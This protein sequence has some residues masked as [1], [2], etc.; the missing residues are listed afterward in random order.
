MNYISAS[1]VPFRRF[2]RWSVLPVSLFVFALPAGL[3]AQTVAFTGA[4]ATVGSGFSVPAG[5]ATDGAGDVFVADSGNGTVHEILAVGGSIPAS[6]TIRTLGS[7]F[8]V[9]ASVAVDGAGNVFVA[10][11]GN[12]AVYEMLAV[13]GSV[14]ASPTIRTLGSGTFIEPVGLAVDG[15]GNLY[16][17]DSKS[18][19]LYEVMAVGGS[20]PT[21]YSIRTLNSVFS[22]PWG[23]AVDGSGD[24]FVAD[25]GFK[26]LYELVAVGGSIPASPTNRALAVD[27]S[28][29]LGVAVDGSG[30]IYVTDAGNGAVYELLAVDGSIPASAGIQMASDLLMLDGKY[31][32]AEPWGVAVDGS[33]NVYV[34]DDFHGA[35]KEHLGSG[36]NFGTKNEGSTSAFLP[37]QFTVLA[38]GTAI[39][40]A[41][42]TEGAAGLDFA[43]AGTGSCAAN[44]TSHAYSAGD[45]CT[46]DVTFTPR[47]AGL[48]RGAVLVLNA[49]NGDV[50]AT[51]PIY[52]IGI[53]PQ[54]GF[55]SGAQIELGSGLDFTFGV[56]V[57]GAGDVFI[58]DVN[59]SRVVEVPVDGGPE[60]TVATGLDEPGCIAVDGAGNV[61][62]ADQNNS[63]VLKL[64]VGGGQPTTVGTGL[65]APFG[66]AVDGPG[67]VFISDN[68]NK[69]VVEV[70]ANGSAQITAVSGLG[71]PEGIAVDGAGDIFIADGGSVLEAP[72]GGGSLIPV[73]GAFSHPVGVAVDAAG[74]VFVA[75]ED[76]SSLIE[77]PAGGGAQILMGNSSF[78]HPAGVAVGAAGDLFVADN[79][80]DR[81]VELPYSRIPSLNFNSGG[82]TQTVAAEN[83]GN[84]P[85]ALPGIEQQTNPAISD[86]SFTLNTTGAADCAAVTASASI[87]GTLGPG[88]ACGLPITFS[89]ANGGTQGGTLV[90]TDNSLTGSPTVFTSQT[91]PLSGTA[92]GNLPSITWPSPAAISYGSALSATQLNATANVAGSFTYAP[93]SGAVLGVGTHTLSVIF[94]PT[95][96]TSYVTASSTVTL[97]VNR[98]VPAI[99]W[100]TPAAITYGTVLSATQLDATSPVAGNFA[101][102]PPAGT[103]LIPGSQTLS[104]TF[105]PTDSADFATVTDS[106]QLTV[107]KDSQT[108]SFTQPASPVAAGVSPVTLSATGGAS[109]N[110]VTFSVVSGPGTL[111]GTNDDVLIVTG[112]GTI[113]LAANQAGN[114][115][116][117]AAAQVTRSVVVTGPP[118][119]MTSP[120][121]GSTLDGPSVTFVW[122]AAANATGYGLW[123]GSTGPGSDNLYYSGEKASTV[124]SLTVSG[125]PVNG[126]TVYVRLIT[127][128]TSS[129]A[130]INYTYTA[131][132]A[133]ALTTPTPGSS[134]AGPSVTFSWSSAANATGYALWAGTT[135]TG[136]GA[137]NLY[138]SGEKASTVASLTVSGLPVNGETIY[139][140]L[141]TYYGA[142]SS[143]ATYTYTS[144]IGGILTTPAPGSKLTGPSVTFGWSVGAGATGYALWIGSTGMGSDNLY[145]SGEKASTVTSLAVSGLPTNGE[146]I[147]VRLITYYGGSSTFFNYT[148]TAATAAVLTTPAPGSTLEGSSVTFS[149]TAAAN[150][151]G[152]ALWAGNSPTESDNLYYSGE[153]AP[154]VT[155][156]TAN[157]L[158]MNGET[159]YVRLITYYGG[160]SAFINYTYTAQ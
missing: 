123:I 75:D 83:I 95:N 66:V 110:P 22:E 39:R 107:S 159:I 42:L 86:S 16:V 98:A 64:P 84:L 13:S 124:N 94:T 1:P 131:A 23:V 99:T 112:P 47:Y 46:V 25:A 6:P 17:A 69:V 109:G 147:Y 24:V 88:Q 62:I 71:G 57:D 12:K 28:A 60:T 111:S 105:T 87:P 35:V 4:G 32:F 27:F 97:T 127:Y 9:P 67:D 151:T 38:S 153:K 2:I 20:I 118:A 116:Y 81:V 146:A 115:I 155:S 121:P 36:T 139:V 150:A 63:R 59:N 21:L 34:S 44:G 5:V 113:V 133:A 140:R 144:A 85:L 126:E 103:G 156:L 3:V 79:F 138:Y 18:H 89:P 30:N 37:L 145:Y 141:I 10:D 52:G 158:P 29:P 117:A 135:G 41:V 56:A 54:I 65:A 76:N 49:E 26:A 70:P 130:F 154:T 129:S 134:L 72:A 106:V 43:D 55:V 80:N 90:L 73:G 125:L 78:S 45:I 96:T 148:Y 136:S 149:W 114:T 50:L 102:D 128:Y 31:A 152:Y 58:A 8:S 77:V 122:T 68:M 53:G 92:S 19:E 132:T 48:R 142:A 11:S 119:A 51:A 33:G 143:T 15:S 61:F 7:G 74:D 157:G 160:S 93:V 100:A 40:T 137:D 14:P 101:Y 91:I 120:A 108:I 104:V 82:G